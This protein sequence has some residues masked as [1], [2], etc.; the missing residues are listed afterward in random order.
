M[1]TELG[2]G[3]DLRTR[4][5]VRPETQYIIYICYAAL[6]TAE[7]TQDTSRQMISRSFCAGWCLCIEL[8]LF[9]CRLL[10]RCR[11][12]SETTAHT[13]CEPRSRPSVLQQ[14]SRNHPVK[15]SWEQL[16]S[17]RP[18]TLRDAIMARPSER[19]LCLTSLYLRTTHAVTH[20]RA[21]E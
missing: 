17:G 13:V 21:S 14:P 7:K 3:A 6:R 2:A 1:T 15:G 19:V 12:T 16:R 5:H 18:S 10:P 4:G 9:C 20:Q 8:N 11:S